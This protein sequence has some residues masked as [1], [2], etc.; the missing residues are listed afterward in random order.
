MDRTLQEQCEEYRIFR[1]TRRVD[2]I[3]VHQVPAGTFAR[4]QDHLVETSS[5]T[6]A[7]FKMPRVLKG[8]DRVQ[9]FLERA[10]S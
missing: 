10:S 4:F 6:S 9:W 3:R 1:D 7:Q 8:A 2:E 5:V